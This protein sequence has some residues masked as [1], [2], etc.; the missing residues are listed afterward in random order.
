VQPKI[1]ELSQ[2]IDR[3]D[4]HRERGETFSA[5]LEYNNALSLDEENVRANF[6]IGLTYLSRGE[7]D[8]AD[9][10]FG[11]LVKLDAAFEDK[12]KFLFNDFGMN[13]RKNKMLN[14]AIDYYTKAIELTK[15]DENL[16]LNIARAQLE[17]KD[18]QNCLDNL[19]KALSLAPQNQ[20][21]IKFAEWLSKNG[22]I[23][24]ELQP[25]FV[26]ALSAKN[27]PATERAPSEPDAAT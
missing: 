15:N 3:G 6:G 27:A 20:V 8:K 26:Q 5:E 25:S 18:I 7:V 1:K 12:H 17:M 21:A 14:Q 24:K 2:S 10:I 13:L 19:L 4:K 23:P 9:N 11:R 22:L 16:Y